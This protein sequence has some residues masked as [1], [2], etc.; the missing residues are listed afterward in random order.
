MSRF[1]GP[2][3]R[4]LS[5]LLLAVLSAFSVPS[6]VLG[7]EPRPSSTSPQV[8]PSVLDRVYATD[9]TEL[10]IDGVDDRR[11]DVD[12]AILDTGIDLDHPDLNVV[13]R[14]NCN[15]ADWPYSAPYFECTNASPT[16]GDEEFDF[17]H[18][19]NSA[20]NSAALDNNIG[21]VGVASGARLWSVDI[22]GEERYGGSPWP[23]ETQR[24]FPTFDLESVI[25]GV[26]W[27]TARADEIEVAHLAVICAPDP[28]AFPPLTPLPVCAGEADVDLVEQ[29]ENAV[30]AS[31]AAGVVYVFSAGEHYETNS[32]VPQRFENMLT[33]SQIADSD[34]LAGGEGDPVC[35][36]DDDHSTL[37]SSWGTGI[38]IASP[39]CAGSHASAQVTGAAAVLASRTNPNNLAGVQGIV[40]TIVNE[41]NDGWID[42]SFDLDEAKE[43]LLDVHDS[44]VFDPVI[45]R[46]FEIRESDGITPCDPYCED[47]GYQG[48]FNIGVVT[49]N[50]ELDIRITSKGAVQT[51]EA[52]ELDCPNE[53]PNSSLQVCTADVWDGQVR[54]QETGPPKIDF[55]ICINQLGIWTSFH[56][57]TVDIVNTPNSTPTRKLVQ[58]GT[59][60]I[61]PSGWCCAFTNTYFED[62]QPSDNVKAVLP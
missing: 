8:V 25:A 31:M 51:T 18:G 49:C 33:S 9:N 41:G 27:V 14:T 40:Q 44:A 53:P 62:H 19:S 39:G 7:A 56:K 21:T 3:G 29:F 1:L 36:A 37:T 48:S 58:N 5:V 35:G 11:V 16:D 57:V 54:L 47:T 22:S 32:F 43:P 6:L 26:K 17:W 30:A 38:E 28:E 52:P 4:M 20:A 59:A 15:G 34:G 60:T 2:C 55:D 24:P 12:I 10:D 45:N 13:E 42:D 61:T 50:A 46:T 23:G